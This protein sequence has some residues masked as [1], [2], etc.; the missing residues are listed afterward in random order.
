MEQICQLSNS[1]TAVVAEVSTRVFVCTH[2]QDFAGA[3]PRPPRLLVPYLEASFGQECQK[4]RCVCQSSTS[5]RFDTRLTRRCVGVYQ[6]PSQTFCS[7]RFVAHSTSQWGTLGV[8]LPAQRR[9]ISSSC[10]ASD[11]VVLVLSE[12]VLV[13]DGCLNCGDADR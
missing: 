6:A 3:L 12:A 10:L 7:K 1:T 4:L 5:L 2:R 8:C 11:F 9:R 13:L